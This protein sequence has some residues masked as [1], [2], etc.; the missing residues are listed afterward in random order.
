MNKNKINHLTAVVLSSLILGSCGTISASND[1]TSDSSSIADSSSSNQSDSQSTTES[2]SESVPDSSL[3]SSDESSSSNSQSSSSSSIQANSYYDGFDFSLRGEQLKTALFKKIA[4]HT[5]VGYDGLYK[6][7]KT[8]DVYSDGK[9]WD[10]YSSYHFSTGNTAGSYSKEGDC[11]NREHTIP[12][13]VFSSKSPMVADAFH[14]VPTDGYVNNRRSNYPHAEV[15]TVSYTSTNNTKVG[16]SATSGVSGNVCEPA[17]EYKGDFARMYFYMVTAYQDK[18]SGWKAYAS[19]SK[20]TY[21]SLS[22]WAKT[23]YLKWSNGDPVSEKEINRNNAI[24]AVQHNRNPYIDYPSLC[25]DV[26]NS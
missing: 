25:N 9:I 19:F 7:Y 17:D 13:S 22:S 3:S 14:V 2:N 15:K 10:M 18:L 5:N 1:S 12:Q 16:T 4:S 11:Y 23:L 8:S 21:P 26:W 6:V 20:N 24:F